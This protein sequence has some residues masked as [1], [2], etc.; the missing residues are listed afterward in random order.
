M[1]AHRSSHVGAD[2]RD[3][4]AWWSRILELDI[5]EKREW[6]APT[7]ETAHLFVDASGEPPY[8]GAVL[9]IDGALYYTDG[10]VPERF[11]QWL[12]ARADAQI[13]ALE[14]AAIAVG[15]SS[16]QHLLR[17]RKVLVFSDNT[18]AEARSG[19]M[20]LPVAMQ[21]VACLR[22]RPPRGV[23]Q[24]RRRTMGNWC[25][26]FGPRCKYAL[27]CSLAVPVC[28]RMHM[29]QAVACSIHIWILRVPSASNIADPPSRRSYKLLEDLGAKR[30]PPM[31]ARQYGLWD[32]YMVV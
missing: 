2:L 18:G 4:L 30:V 10:P 1:L 3:A 15:L 5:V 27:A 13:M 19:C 25:M 7:T 28:V 24:L 29:G 12:H 6:N 22:L 20:C 31:L 26:R 17:G 23:D 9:A 14:I 16:F 11:M 8:I 32:P 21:C